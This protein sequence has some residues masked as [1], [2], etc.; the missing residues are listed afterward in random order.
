MVLRAA[1]LA[2]FPSQVEVGMMANGHFPAAVCHAPSLSASAL[3]QALPVD[4]S[5]CPA[6]NFA[7]RE[8]AELPSPDLMLRACSQP[9]ILS[10]CA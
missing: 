9:A 10:P 5:N 6:P 2:G 8:E 1:G 4:C 3:L 7:G